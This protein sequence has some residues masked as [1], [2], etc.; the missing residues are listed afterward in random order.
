[1]VALLNHRFKYWIYFQQLRKLLLD[2]LHRIPTN[3]HL[4]PF[5]KSIL[6]L[7]FHLLEVST[8]S[9]IFSYYHEVVLHS[10]ICFHIRLVFHQQ[11][12]SH[13]TYPGNPPKYSNHTQGQFLHLPLYPLLRLLRSKSDSKVTRKRI[14][15]QYHTGT[16]LNST[17]SMLALASLSM[18]IYHI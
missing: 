3:D 13:I 9:V 15:D 2:I 5:V 16:A 4:R 12:N 6:Q 10:L 11:L 18:D 17:A 1:M 8:K 14:L 7:C